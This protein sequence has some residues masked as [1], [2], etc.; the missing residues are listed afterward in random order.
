FGQVGW[1]DEVGMVFG[2]A[3]VSWLFT[4][5]APRKPWVTFVSGVLAGLMLCTSPGVFLSFMPLLAAL[6]LWRVN[7]LR[8]V[9]VS[10]AAGALGGALATA[11]CLT[12][13]FLAQ[14]YFYRQFFR[15]VRGN[16]MPLRVP[17]ISGAVGEALHYS[18]QR[19]FILFATVPVLCLGMV[20]LWRSGRIQE[21]ITLFIAPLV[22]LVFVWLVYPPSSYWWFLQPWFL[23]LAIVVIAD[24]L[25]IRRSRPVA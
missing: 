7:N 3:N 4:S 5:P 12:P 15:S 21:V 10:V 18:P 1:P 22:G 9:V 16:V 25:W 14:P 20:V 8:Q 19:L 6:L 17:D 24:F 2:F 11:L 13:L 23:L